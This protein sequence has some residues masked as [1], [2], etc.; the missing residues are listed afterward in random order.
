MT[1]LALLS[2]SITSIEA[3]DTNDQYDQIVALQAR[4]NAEISDIEGDMKE[5]IDHAHKAHKALTSRRK[6]ATQP[7]KELKDKTSRLIGNYLVKK[8]KA[9]RMAQELLEAEAQKQSHA[10]MRKGDHEGAA[11]LVANVEAPKIAPDAKNLRVKTTYS[12][13]VVDAQAIP[14]EWLTPDIARINEAVR[15]AK[16]DIVIQGIEVITENKA[17][18]AKG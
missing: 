5:A 12:A 10:L 18:G 14:R 1:S 7:Y 17:H 15:K 4:C 16:G 6:E 13:E 11:Q 2:E 3:I 9:E 8:R